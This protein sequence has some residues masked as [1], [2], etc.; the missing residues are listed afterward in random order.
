MSENNQKVAI[1]TH[2]RLFLVLFL[3][4]EPAF[5][6]GIMAPTLLKFGAS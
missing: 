6:P 1:E 4:D 2:L 5:C 3:Y